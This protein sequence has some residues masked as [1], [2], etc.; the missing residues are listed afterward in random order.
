MSEGGADTKNG[1]KILKKKIEEERRDKSDRVVNPSKKRKS[2][3]ERETVDEKDKRKSI[4][5]HGPL[6]LS[7]E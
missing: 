1:K 2:L 7:E 5:T 6:P 4:V 3:V